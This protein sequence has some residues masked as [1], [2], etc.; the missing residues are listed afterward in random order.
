MKPTN[1]NVIW[2]KRPTFQAWLLPDP[3]S[4]HYFRCKVCQ[5]KLDLGN[6]G[7]GALVKHNKSAKHIKNLEEINSTSAAMLTSWTRPAAKSVG[8]NLPTSS[9]A[10]VIKSTSEA[11]VVKADDIPSTSNAFDNWAITDDVLRAEVFIL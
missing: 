10:P 11:T 1:F 5:I 6:M 8:S 4:K 9:I 7:R 2:K 3:M